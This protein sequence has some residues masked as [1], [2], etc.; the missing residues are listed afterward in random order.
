MAF[1]IPYSK[2]LKFLS[3]K[4]INLLIILFVTLI[5]CTKDEAKNPLLAYSDK[6][7]FDSIKN[8]SAFIYYKNTP[9]VYSGTNGPHGSFTLKFNK[10]AS[11]VLTDNG[12]L[13]IGQTFPNGSFVVKEVK[14]S[15]LFAFMYKNNNSW[16]WGEV[17]ANGNTVFSVNKDP[18]SACISCHSQSGHRDLVVSFAFY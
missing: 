14:S 6:A 4:K 13:P 18:N 17:A 9:T 10:I 3:M 11:A 12:K 15:G 16:L 5:S 8:E 1:E 2:S 7:L